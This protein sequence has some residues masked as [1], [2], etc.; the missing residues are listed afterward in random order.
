ME[1]KGQLVHRVRQGPTGPTGQ[2]G[3]TGPQGPEGPANC[4]LKC[5]TFEEFQTGS[6]NGN[7][8]EYI[9]N[10]TWGLSITSSVGAPIIY[11]DGGVKVLSIANS[12]VIPVFPNL[13][14][15]TISEL[16]AGTLIFAND[17]FVTLK[18]L[19]IVLLGNGAS[20][21]V[22]VNCYDA[23]M[24]G[25]LIYSTVIP[26]A[27]ISTTLVDFDV[28]G[29]RR[30]EVSSNSVIGI[31][32]VCV[33]NPAS[34][35]PTHTFPLTDCWRFHEGDNCQMCL[36]FYSESQQNWID[37]WC[38]D[39]VTC[40]NPAINVS[41]V[42]DCSQSITSNSLD[43]IIIIRDGVKRMIDALGVSASKVS[44]S[45]Y[46]S[47]SP[48]NYNGAL[49][50]VTNVSGG[51]FPLTTQAQ[52][53]NAKLFVDQHVIFYH[54]S[55][56]QSNSNQNNSQY[57]NWQAGLI[58]A[59]SA[60][61]SG[62]FNGPLGTKPDVI[63]FITD[64]I[65]TA[66]YAD[67]RALPQPLTADPTGGNVNVQN[68]FNVDA[69]NVAV[70]EANYIKTNQGSRIIGIGVGD[71]TTDATNVNRLKTLCSNFNNVIGGPVQGVDYFIANTFPL[72]NAA[73]SG[74]L[75]SEAFCPP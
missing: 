43:N 39:K 19:E 14:N 23:D 65:P 28:E 5:I 46:A 48:P 18:Q 64:G 37:K 75:E 52:V 20:T 56:G 26:V 40:I 8:R 54:N 68:T 27:A 31:G 16:I 29:C 61:V 24:G 72:F 45:S 74:I 33:C 15:P 17:T 36:Q 12:N 60:G 70:S 38:V 51:F 11:N 58:S 4:I 62:H 35:G 49:N 21:N 2:T 1:L 42:V 53:D 67:T 10:N 44:I 73:V 30:I 71:I 7:G 47:R 34:V 63:I 41:I 69:Y 25:N 3:Q 55:S 13:P 22:T 66:Y 57:T 9:R 6:Y 50:S 59:E 32:K